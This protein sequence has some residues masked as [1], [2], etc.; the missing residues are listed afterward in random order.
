MFSDTPGILGVVRN[1][2]ARVPQPRG[3]SGTDLVHKL[4]YIC[5]RECVC[6]RVRVC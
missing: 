1:E 4:Q 5:V 3:V 6:V 2:M